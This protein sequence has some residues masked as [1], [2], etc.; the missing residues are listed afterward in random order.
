MIKVGLVGCGDIAR[1]HAQGWEAIANRASVVA[2]A[3][4]A[5]ESTRQM[6][7][8]FGGVPSFSDYR[9]MLAE[10]ELD[11]VDL[12]LP[13][14]LHAAAIIAAAEAGKHILCEKP[15]CLSLAEAGTIDSAVR[16][17]GVTMMCAHNQ[18]FDPAVAKAKEMIEAGTI[19][20]TYMVRT[21]DCFRHTK[22]LNQWGWR[23]DAKSMGGGCLIDTGYHPTYLL[24]YFAGQAPLQVS[25][26]AG[27]F[28]IKSLD[29]EDSAMMS[30][31]FSDGTLG[32]VLT[33][34]AWDWPG[35]AWQFQVLGEK[36]QIYGRGNRLFHQPIGWQPASLDLP[37]TPNFKAEIA[38]FVQCVE[39][40][41]RPLHTNVEGTQVLKL[42]LGAYES[43]GN[44]SIV[45]LE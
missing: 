18:L 38:H 33:S 24:L 19:G 10:V 23:A 21:C 40:G 39:T 3:D 5:E 2:V 22:P 26:M 6:A 37:P 44:N 28:F 11:A 4:V 13:H 1:V 34:W 43:I 17:N 9:A 15:L 30:V 36:G 35:G 16:A 31:K 45:T 8:R 41:R 29:G 7:E 20:E 25:A 32:Q 12:C 14:H 27:R 42:I